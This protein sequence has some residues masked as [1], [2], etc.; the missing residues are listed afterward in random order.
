MT[1]HDLALAA[2]RFSALIAGFVILAGFAQNSFHI[3]QL[4]VASRALRRQRGLPETSLVWRRYAEAAPPIA[5][6][7]PAYNEELTIGESLRSLLA[8]QYPSFEVVVVNDGSGDGTLQAL[9]D[10]FELEPVQRSYEAIAPCAAI[11]GLYGSRRQPRLLVIDK[12]NGGKADALNAAINLARAPIVCSMDAD[13]LL[14]PDALLRAVRPFVEDPERVVAVGGTVRVANGCD[15]RFGRVSRVG[16]PRNF[17]ALLQTIEYLRAFLMARLA[18]SEMGSLMIISGAFGLFRREAVRAVGGYTLGTVGEDMELVVKIH[19]HYRRERMPYRVVFVPEP[20][21][22]TEAPETLQILGR[23][24]ARWHRG[25]LETFS[26]HFG[27]LFN[28]RYGRVGSVGFGYILL[29]DVLG[30]FVELAGYVLIPAF[31]LLGILNTEFLWAFLAVSF[32]FG[33]V[34]SVG[35]LAL[36]ETELR[37]FPDVKSLAVLMAAAVVENF[38]YRQIN[39]VWRLWGAWQFLRK[40][41]SWGV[42]TRR[43]FSRAAA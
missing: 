37:R 31:W 8:L 25:A 35:A 1:L 43:G 14:E 18:W 39:N 26:K 15:I 29:V 20:V 40:Q 41:E 10:T 36:E 22:W 23:Q 17:L 33:V 4:L 2:A 6:L 32:G 3:W 38:G 28:P 34:I 11:R 42:M 16:V 9:I 5:L 24:R 7:V 30:P 27:M 13:S 12:E 19:R 21:C